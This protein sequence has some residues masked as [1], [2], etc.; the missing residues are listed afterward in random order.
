MSKILSQ[1]EIDALLRRRPTSSRHRARTPRTA[2]ASRSSSTTSAAPTACRRSRFTRCTSCTIDSRE[3]SH[4]AVSLPARRDRVVAGLGRAVLVFRVP[5]VA[6]R[7]DGVLR[8][9]DAAVR[10]TWR[11]R[12]QPGRRLHDDRSHARR[13]R[14]A[15]DA[16][17]RAHRHRAERHRLG[18]QAAARDAV[19]TVARRSST[20]LRH[21]RPRDAAADAAG[22]RRRTKSSS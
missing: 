6:A 16:E 18:G 20:C 4:L 21:P 2:I 1:D 12:N 8:A 22:R 15:V 19:R 7:S 5:D 3:T 17:A 14:P 10:R 11:P 9:V 13:R